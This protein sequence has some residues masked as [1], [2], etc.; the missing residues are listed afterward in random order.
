MK[1]GMRMNAGQGDGGTR[2]K[3]LPCFG[4]E[5][6]ADLRG[7]GGIK[8]MDSLPPFLRLDFVGLSM[9]RKDFKFVF[10]RL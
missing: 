5:E 2:N 7:I 4:R 8:R 6:N 3:L 9:G 1:D 10:I